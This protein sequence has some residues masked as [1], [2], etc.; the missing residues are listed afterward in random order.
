MHH[1]VGERRARHDDLEHDRRAHGPRGVRVEHTRAQPSRA[2]AQPS[3]AVRGRPRAGAAEPLVGHIDLNVQATQIARV[4][5]R[6]G[7]RERAHSVVELFEFIRSRGDVH[8]H[9]ARGAVGRARPLLRV[10]ARDAR[11]EVRLRARA[12]GTRARGT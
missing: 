9:A 11:R 3:R 4:R 1:R 5:R 7:A 8:E 10:R 2:R 12:A 6:G